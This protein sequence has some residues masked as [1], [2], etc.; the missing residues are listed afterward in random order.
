[1]SWQWSPGGALTATASVGMAVLAA[2][3]WRRRSGAEAAWLALALLAAAAWALAYSMELVSTTASTRQSWGDAKYVGIC[4]LPP[5][6]VMFV[7]AY[8]GRT[9]WLRR[10]TSLLLVVEPVAVLGLLSNK[11]THDLIRYYRAGSTSRVAQSG[12]LFWPHSAYTYLL[13][14]GATGL[15]VLRLGRLSP[16]YRRQ[17]TV[18]VATLSVPFVCNILFNVGVPPFDSVDLTPFAFLGAG[19]V[20]VWGVLRF[21]LV[22]LRPVARS[23]AFQRINDLVITLDPLSRVIDVNAAA[24][25]AFGL[26]AE[27]LIGRQ[28]KT[29]LPGIGRVLEASD[30]DRPREQ[31]LAGR[32]YELQA[33]PLTDRHGRPLATLLVARDVTERKVVE[34]RLAHQ[35]LHDPLTGAA[36]RTLF[37]ERLSHALDHATRTGRPVAVLFLDLDLFKAVNDEL[38]HAAG[39]KVLVEVARRLHASVRKDD[40]VARMGGDEFAILLED[41]VDEHEPAKVAKHLHDSLS[42]PLSIG[43]HRLSLTASIGVATGFGL[44]PD[45]LVRRADESMYVAKNT[46]PHS[47]DLTSD[48]PTQRTDSPQP[49]SPARSKPP[50]HGKHADPD[51]GN[52]GGTGRS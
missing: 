34:Q 19:A 3:A 52:H 10:R 5:A 15:L 51:D 31:C 36:N 14:W 11:H 23:Q 45:E 49:N 41:V 43:A 22:G 2:F 48:L 33:S 37:F 24:A 28:M 27:H 38:G 4:A 25:R 35:A 1:M 29:L 26:P 46:R 18:L 9:S 7:S 8:T 17:S 13:L 20:L 50:A 44:D 12:A 42:P 6:W 16:V 40:T 32:T 47:I 30:D 21:R 39:D